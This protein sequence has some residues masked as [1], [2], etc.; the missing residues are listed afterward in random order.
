MERTREIIQEFRCPESLIAEIQRAHWTWAKTYATTA[1]HWYI[2]KHQHPGLFYR[3]SQ[4][5]RAYGTDQEYRDTGRVH[6]YLV[7]GES[8]FWQ[9]G[10]ILYRARAD[11]R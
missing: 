7:I 8:Q 4:A 9:I 11:A 1:P 6:R 3:L 2:V 5:I 10:V